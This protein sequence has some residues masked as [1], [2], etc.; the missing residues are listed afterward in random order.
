MCIFLVGLRLLTRKIHSIL[1]WNSIQYTV[2]TDYKKKKPK[3][4]KGKVDIILMTI[5][6][7]LLA[8][9]ND[10]FA[11]GWINTCFVLFLWKWNTKFWGGFH[12]PVILSLSNCQATQWK[13]SAMAENMN[14]LPVVR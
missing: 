4:N 5:P 11:C 9:E 6:C 8:I 13:H 14:K 12:F 1:L 7:L 2:T 10:W 3:A